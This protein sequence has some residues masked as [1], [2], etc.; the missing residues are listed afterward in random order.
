MLSSSILN[1]LFLSLLK[2]FIFSKFVLVLMYEVMTPHTSYLL[3][4]Y[5]LRQGILM[6]WASLELRT[7]LTQPLAEITGVHPTP[8]YF[9]L[10]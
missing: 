8:T 6:S 7:L 2:S 10:K 3:T 5:I 1:E 4:N 9:S